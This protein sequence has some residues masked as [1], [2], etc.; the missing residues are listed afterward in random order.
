MQHFPI[1]SELMGLIFEKSRDLKRVEGRNN[2]LPVIS[3]FDI[4][5]RHSISLW[6]LCSHYIPHEPLGAI[7]KEPNLIV[8]HITIASPYMKWYSTRI[9]IQ[10]SICKYIN[11]H[12]GSNSVYADRDFHGQDLDMECLECLD[13][14]V[15]EQ[16]YDDSTF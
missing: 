16:E 2:M 4:M 15:Y 3:S 6:E 8:R 10:V 12:S 14:E 7:P 5:Y 13:I 9:H 1:P 11:Y